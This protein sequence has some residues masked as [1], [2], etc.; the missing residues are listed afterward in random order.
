MTENITMNLTVDGK[1][2][3]MLMKASGALGVEVMQ[4]LNDAVSAYF[5]KLVTDGKI[6]AE[7][8]LSS[9]SSTETETDYT[10]SDTHRITDAKKYGLSP[11]ERRKLAATQLKN[12]AKAENGDP[13]A[14]NVM[15]TYYESGNG[16]EKD[17][18]KA[19]YWY[20]KSADQGNPNAQYHL[21]ILYNKA[22]ENP[23]KSYYW[24][25]VARLCGFN[26]TS[27]HQ[28]YILRL[29]EKLSP[30]QIKLAQEEAVKKVEAIR[31]RAGVK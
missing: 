30:R 22:E 28:D 27:M 19:I 17:Y 4:V 23:L 25:E 11:S 3:D 7:S 26:I 31:K 6:S 1:L 2:R 16:V 14:Q 29:T 8:A 21:A 12:A 18:W 20:T 9:L 15:G 5:R 24:F 10:L 13:K